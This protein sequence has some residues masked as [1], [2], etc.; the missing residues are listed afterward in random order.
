MLTLPNA[1]PG[2]TATGCVTVTYAGPPARIR[3]YGSRTVSGL[4][5]YVVLTV[6]RGTGRGSS[7]GSCAAFQPD[8]INHRGLGAGV[9][10]EGPLSMLPQS[11]DAAAPDPAGAAGATWTNGDSHAYR[12]HV[13]VADDNAA[14]GLTVVQS[15]T[16]EARE[17]P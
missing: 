9:V 16:W 5:D 14:Q 17:I 15:F 6:T 7:P 12:F 8:P 3:L 1:K 10:Y 4:E 13:R 11:W 2:L